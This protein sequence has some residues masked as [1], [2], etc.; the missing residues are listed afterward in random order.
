MVLQLRQKHLSRWLWGHLELEDGVWGDG[1]PYGA[2]RR[3]MG[4]GLGMGSRD[5]GTWLSQDL[6]R[7]SEAI[8]AVT[9]LG[10]ALTQNAGV[11]M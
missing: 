3:Q 5:M 9:S 8:I 2:W 6:G 11:S 4:P 10:R 1:M 7:I